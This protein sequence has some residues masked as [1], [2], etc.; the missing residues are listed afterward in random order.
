MS[1]QVAINDYRIK[2][3]ILFRLCED[4]EADPVAIIDMLM[5]ERRMIDGVHCEHLEAMRAWAI[6]VTKG[7][8]WALEQCA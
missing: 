1:R 8:P 2:T 6:A 7:E 3:A 5:A 4:Y